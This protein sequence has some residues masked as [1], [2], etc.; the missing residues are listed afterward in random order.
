V[1][2][3]DRPMIWTA[4]SSTIGTRKEIGMANDDDAWKKGR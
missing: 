4:G 1:L 2:A 3:G